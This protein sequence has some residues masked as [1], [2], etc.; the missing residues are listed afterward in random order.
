M[1]AHCCTFLLFGI[2][3]RQ[4]CWLA[5]CT[6]SAKLALDSLHGNREWV[7]YEISKWP[8]DD[9]LATSQEYA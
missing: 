3:C 5:L 1:V 2:Y 8:I 4:I 6:L 7:R 9:F